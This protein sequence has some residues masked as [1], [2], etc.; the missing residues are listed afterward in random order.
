MM[1]IKPAT[2]QII[3]ECIDEIYALDNILKASEQKTKE[4]FINSFKL[5]Y[6][7]INFI[8][9]DNKQI[10]ETN[11]I[12]KDKQYLNKYISAFEKNLDYYL[13]IGYEQNIII[14]KI[15]IWLFNLYKEDIEDFYKVQSSINTLFIATPDI[16]Y[17][18]KMLTRKKRRLSDKE[19]LYITNYKSISYLKEAFKFFKY[20]PL[21]NKNIIT[22]LSILLYKYLMTQTSIKKNQAKNILETMFYKLDLPTTLRVD[23]M[24]QI[25]V[26]TQIENI[27]IYAYPSTKKIYSLY[28]FE[29]IAQQLSKNILKYKKDSHKYQK[30]INYAKKIYPPN[31]TK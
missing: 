3:D 29:N 11:R 10:Q 6:N 7:L 1:K 19:K 27:L 4:F 17:K 16:K 13:N 18:I 31:S 20:T 12:K 2:Q 22:S 21:T 5:H 8:S 14:T 15:N 24:N 26:K 28:D 25:Y 30:Y 23:Q 9:S